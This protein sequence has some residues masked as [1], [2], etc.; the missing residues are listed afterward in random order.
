MFLN[1]LV[2]IIA[3]AYCFSCRKVGAYMCEACAKKLRYRSG[4]MSYPPGVSGHI[5]FFAYDGVFKNTL[6]GAKYFSVRPAL[7]SIMKYLP[8]QH[9][10]EI[11]ECISPGKKDV[12]LV[13]IP[14]H[15]RKLK[16]RGFN[17]TEVIAYEIAKRFNVPMKT[18]AIV[19]T[20]Y[21]NQQARLIH[22]ERALNM[23]D[24]FS[25]ER[26]EDIRDKILV[27]VDDVWTTGST[28]REVVRALDK[29]PTCKAKKIFALTLAR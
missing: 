15:K 4:F 25:L 23:L 3:P 22:A 2:N 28:I 12:V 1:A 11:L 13:P 10:D 20:K 5:R 29:V 18:H 19:R 7:F 26:P 17:Q 16:Q 24:A 27:L 21:T 6:R 9:L 14:L 8:W